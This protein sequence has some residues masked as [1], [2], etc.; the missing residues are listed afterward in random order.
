MV[1]W[2]QGDIHLQIAL[3]RL[4]HAYNLGDTARKPQVPYKETIKRRARSSI[5]ASSGNRA[6][7]A[8]SPTSR[9]R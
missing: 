2:G 7:T 8:S 9:S 4:K 3:D 1:L 5:R 6:A